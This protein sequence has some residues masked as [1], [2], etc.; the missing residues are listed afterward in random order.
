M[1][2]TVADKQKEKEERRSARQRQQLQGPQ[3]VLLPSA[4][5][6]N[7][8]NGLTRVRARPR[9]TQAPAAKKPHRYRPGAIA[10]REIRKYQKS[11]DRLVRR[12]PFQRLCREILDDVQFTDIKRMQ[13]EAIDCLQVTSFVCRNY[14]I[15]NLS[16]H[17]FLFFTGSNRGL[18]CCSHGGKSVACHPW[19]ASHDHGQ[20][21]AVG[22]ATAQRSFLNLCNNVSRLF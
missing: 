12:L 3:A 7:P 4:R 21:Y 17:T 5:G 13:Q 8:R 1:A 9:P 2:R 10:L 20:G 22:Q 16:L 19:Q 14:N 18:H 6:R 11:T 15:S